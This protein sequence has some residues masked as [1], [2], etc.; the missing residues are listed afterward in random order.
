MFH[1]PT[2]TE[3]FSGIGNY[4]SASWQ[5]FAQLIP[6]IVGISVG[7]ILVL[8]IIFMLKNSTKMIALM[9]T[10]SPSDNLQ[11]RMSRY[12]G[13]SSKYSSNLRRYQPSTDKAFKMSPGYHKVYTKKSGN[14]PGGYFADKYK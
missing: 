6:L 5:N 11:F 3:V 8:V 9:G 1:I 13:A 7:I 14:Y 10:G 2:S 12:V 4:A